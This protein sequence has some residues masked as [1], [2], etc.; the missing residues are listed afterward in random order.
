VRA[1]YNHDLL[2]SLLLP[3]LVC[4]GSLRSVSERA[5]D[6]FRLVDSLFDEKAGVAPSVAGSI[7]FAGMFIWC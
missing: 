3:F 5:N 4:A 7:R 1:A 6:A 2:L